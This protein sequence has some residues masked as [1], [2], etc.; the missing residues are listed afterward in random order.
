MSKYRILEK[1]GTKEFIKTK[2]DSCID[3]CPRV[4]T[5]LGK[6]MLSCAHLELTNNTKYIPRYIVQEEITNI[7]SV[8]MLSGY[9]YNEWKDLKEFNNLEE[10]RQ[11]KNDLELEEGRVIE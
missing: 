10:A 2:P 11:Y 3:N 7:D 9:A 4:K 6:M 1:T 5:K 8:N